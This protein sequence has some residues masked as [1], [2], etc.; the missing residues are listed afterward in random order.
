MGVLFIV[1]A[2]EGAGKTAL[3]AGLAVN[4]IKSGKTPGYLKS[5][6]NDKDVAIMKK[7]AII[8]AG[9]MGLS[10][11]YE[12]LK[13]GYKVTVFE[14]DDRIGGMSASFDFDGL[15]IERYYHFVCRPDYPLFD[16]L[17]ELNI[18]DALKWVETK[19]GF[20]YEGKLFKWG[21]PLYLLAFPELDMISKLRYGIHVFLST[22]RKSWKD[23]DSQNAITWIKKWIGLR[24]YDKLC[25]ALFFRS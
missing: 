7:V 18:F 22:R 10:C 14:A 5:G 3:C 24:A 13:Q 4:F 15:R 6:K 8:G 12:L 25:C 23:L 2:E 20:Y 1:S 11:A 17:K 16:L 19:M 9:V 21:N